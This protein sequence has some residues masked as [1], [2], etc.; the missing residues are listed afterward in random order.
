MDVQEISFNEKITH[1]KHG[2]I[3]GVTGYGGEVIGRYSDMPEKFPN[4]ASFHTFRVNHPAGWFCTT[5]ALSDIC[6]VWEQ[7]GSGLINFHG[8]TGDIILL[9][10]PTENLQA[11]FDSLEEDLPVYAECAGLMYL[12][13]GINWQG[14]W[15]E[16]V[17]AIAADVKMFKRP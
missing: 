5:K 4:I 14:K 2:G 8:S 17:G 13:R 16:M 9:G 6:D 11:C 1:W 7:Y 12:C 15:H 10:A 3:V